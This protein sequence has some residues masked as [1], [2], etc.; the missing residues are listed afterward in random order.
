[1]KKSVCLQVLKNQGQKSLALTRRLHLINAELKIQSDNKHIYIPLARQPS[2]PTLK[3]LQPRLKVYRICV[4][5]LSKKE[6]KAGSSSSF[7][8]REVPSDLLERV[9]RR[10]MMLS[11]T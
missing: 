3:T 2:K 8:K 5:S 7:L 9:F 6:K 4:R 11:A 10:L 1:M